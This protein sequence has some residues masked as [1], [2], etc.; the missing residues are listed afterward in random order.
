MQASPTPPSETATEFC[1][2]DEMYPVDDTSFLE[3]WDEAV[4]AVLVPN[5]EN[6]DPAAPD[7]G[8]LVLTVVTL[9]PDRCILGSMFY[10]SM[11][12]TVRTGTI[13][14]LVEHWPGLGAAPEAS[15]IPSGTLLPQPITVNVPVEL[16]AGDWVQIENESF[17]GF[18]NTS[19]VVATFIVAGLKPDQDP[20]S[21]RCGGGCRG[22]P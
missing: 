1:D 14:I 10:P 6:P 9:L 4:G 20:D 18:S 13:N 8:K 17:V 22:Q 12:M 16:E 2:P 11:I 15:R 21:G 5:I 19:D 3:P 7:S